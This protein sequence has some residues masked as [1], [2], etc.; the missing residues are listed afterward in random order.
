MHWLT[1]DVHCERDVTQPLPDL[2]EVMLLRLP[3]SRDL[4]PVNP[5][6][7]AG[8]LVVSAAMFESRGTAATTAAA[9]VGALR[10]R[11]GRPVASETAR[12]VQRIHLSKSEAICNGSCKSNGWQQSNFR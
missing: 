7:A 10:G 1:G 4:P 3:A 8:S 2:G 6:Y 5:R 9:A 11:A 12:R